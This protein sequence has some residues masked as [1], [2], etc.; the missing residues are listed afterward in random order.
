MIDEKIDKIVELDINDDELDDELFEDM[1]VDI[2]SFVDQPAIQT[3]FLY[4]NEEEFITPNP[5]QSGYE[6]IGTKMKNG[7]EVPNCV[8]IE[9]NEEFVM[10]DGKMAYH[11]IEQ[12][13][14]KAEEMGC[15]GYHEHEYEGETYYM[16]CETHEEN[17]ETYNDYPEGAK[18]N[19]CRAVKYAEENGWGSCGEATGKR[20]ASQLCNGEN[21]SRDTIARMASFARHQQHKDVPYTEGCGGLMWDAWGGSSGVNWAQSKLEELELAKCKKDKNGKCKKSYYS[22]EEKL[23]IIEF[24]ENDENGIYITKDDLYMDMTLNKFAGVG[25]VITAI[26]SLDILKRLSIKKDNP[27]E[28]Y[29]KYTGPPAQRDF[30]KAMMRLSNAGKMFS[31]DEVNRMSSLNKDFGPRGNSSYSKLTWKG[32]PNCTH[33]WTKLE[34]FKG[35]TGTKV[36]IASNTPSNRYEENAMKSNN[37]NKPAPQGSTKN[38]AYLKKPK[39]WNFSYDDEK[40]IV[41]GPVMIPNKMILRRDEEG[42]PFYIYFTKDTIRKMSEK[43]FAKNKHNN[44]DINHDENITTENTLIESW[45]SESIKHDKSYKYGFALPEGTWYVSYKINDDETWNLIKEGEL[46]GFSLAGGFIQKMKPIDPE[47]KLNDIKDIL[48]Q[49]K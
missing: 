33:Y 35:E 17:F 36:I 5:C 15:E 48:K 19:A 14:A 46:R 26:R 43:F 28:I 12:A 32:G 6:A 41:T 31:T 45:I 39:S 16:P 11:T 18:N 13:I 21:I 34:V 24:A 23:A 30:C 7:R 1:G 9:N 49:V 37:R 42:N 10:I 20:R 22:E 47:A 29:W 44:T 38:N 40:R 27:P 8:P 4:F 25:D 3:D 2:I